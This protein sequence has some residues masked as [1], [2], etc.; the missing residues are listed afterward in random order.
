[1]R[2]MIDSKKLKELEA[3]GGTKWY[4]HEVTLENHAYIA[5]FSMFGEP[6]KDTQLT[7]GNYPAI[8]ISASGPSAPNTDN[9]FPFIKIYTN[10]RF[11]LNYVSPDG[12]TI[13][14]YEFNKNSINSDVVTQ[15]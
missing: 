6:L 14:Q 12:K 1:M 15:L 9:F 7:I 2:R 13:K 10:G 4:K 8:I 11:M 5:F 3:N